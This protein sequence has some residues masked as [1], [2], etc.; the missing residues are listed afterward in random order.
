MYSRYISLSYSMSE[1]GQILDRK[2]IGSPAIDMLEEEWLWI[3]I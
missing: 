1:K 2:P 3:F